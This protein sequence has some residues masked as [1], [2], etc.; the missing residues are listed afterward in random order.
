[1]H[2]LYL[3]DLLHLHRQ[4][5]AEEIAQHRA[6]S[7]ARRIRRARRNDRLGAATDGFDLKGRQS[8]SPAF[9]S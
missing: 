5:L 9:P 2:N 6:V 7:V 8:C 3:T 1:M 4:E